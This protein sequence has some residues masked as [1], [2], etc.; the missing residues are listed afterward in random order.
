MYFGMRTNVSSFKVVSSLKNDTHT[1][2][3]VKIHVK[4]FA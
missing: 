3:A 4:L 2:N 1:Q